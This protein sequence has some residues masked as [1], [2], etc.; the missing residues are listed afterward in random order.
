MRSPVREREGAVGLEG[1]APILLV[2][3]SRNLPLL[4]TR[5]NVRESPFTM[6]AMLCQ[7]S[8]VRW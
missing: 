8:A 4:V 3:V 1:S 6:L 7:D 5:M 2:G